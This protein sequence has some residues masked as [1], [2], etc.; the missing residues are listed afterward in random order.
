MNVRPVSRIIAAIAII[1]V[2]LAAPHELFAAPTV[3][4]YSPLEDNFSVTQP[5]VGSGQGAS[6]KTNPVNDFPAGKVGRGVR[7]DAKNEFVRFP[8]IVGTTQNVEL[9]SG[10]IEFWYKPNYNHNDEFN[11]NILRI[12]IDGK[13]GMIDLHKRAP[14]KASDLEI[15]FRDATNTRRSTLVSG[16]S[17][18]WRA[19]TWVHVQMTWNTRLLGDTQVAR[20]YLNGVELA[21]SQKI[22]KRMK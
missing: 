21:Y 19:S 1:L 4:L 13:A 5:T 11:H 10:T 15:T 12:G 2:L 18:S 16:S 6:L 8:S 17:Y 20:L 3:L 7:I 9:D 14:S 22:T